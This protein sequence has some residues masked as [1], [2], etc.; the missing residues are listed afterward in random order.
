MPG[1][2]ASGALLYHG[3]LWSEAPTAP[4]WVSFDAEHS[5]V[6]G[7]QLFTYAVGDEPFK[8]LYFDGSRCA[9]IPNWDSFKN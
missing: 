4:D 1:T 2:I 8:V 5:L 9:R 7:A 3:T 6:F